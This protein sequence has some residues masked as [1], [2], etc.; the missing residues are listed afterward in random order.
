MLMLLKLLSNYKV[1]LNPQLLLFVVS[2]LV[3]TTA[4][5]SGE[6]DTPWQVHGF[7]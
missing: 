6:L 1:G 3:M 2:A 7:I 4:N 5:A